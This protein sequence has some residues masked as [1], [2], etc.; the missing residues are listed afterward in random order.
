[1]SRPVVSFFVHDLSSNPISRAAPLARALSH[2]FDVEVLGFLHGDTVY[3]PYRGAFDYRVLPCSRDITAVLRQAPVLASLARGDVMYGCKPLVT[4]FGPALLASGFGR[5]RPLLLDV[6]DDEWVP[7]GKGAIDFVVRDVIRGW[8]HATAWKYT[9]LLHPFTVCA[10]DVTVS[11]QALHRRY[12]G[13]VVRHG[14]DERRFDPARAPDRAATRRRWH[15]PADVPLALFAGMPQP[16]K[17]FETLRQAL[18][19]PA[20]RAW[21]LVLAG[22]SDHPE[23]RACAQALGL[24]CHIIGFVAQDDRP[25]L[26]AAADAVPVPQRRVAFAESQIPAKALEA[27]AMGCAVVGTRV[28]DLPELLGGGK[29]GWLIAPDDAEGLAEA[30]GAIASDPA[31]RAR[32]AAKAR[33][34]FLEHASSAAIRARLVPMIEAVLARR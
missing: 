15:L 31:E 16:H 13:H 8:R 4:S 11:S 25:A 32:T 21:H 28:G 34:W 18:L 17:G 24:R 27:M 22:P 23:F 12:G 20:A 33:A 26:L 29:R 7:M 5:R 19:E 3:E 14:P 10:S 1:M 9:R 2:D 6:E 30:L